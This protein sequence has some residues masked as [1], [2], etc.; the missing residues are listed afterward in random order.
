MLRKLRRIS[1]K[2][3][4][5]AASF[6]ISL[7]FHFTRMEGGSL[8]RGTFPAKGF[9]MIISEPSYHQTIHENHRGNSEIRKRDR[10]VFKARERLNYERGNRVTWSFACERIFVTPVLE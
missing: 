6:T 2:A 4:D 9:Q 7:H 8:E 3:V 1:Y 10:S 5:R